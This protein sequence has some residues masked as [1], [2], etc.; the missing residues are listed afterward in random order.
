MLYEIDEIFNKADKI[1][2]E[3][4]DQEIIKLFEFSYNLQKKLYKNKKNSEMLFLIPLRD[5]LVKILIDN[6]DLSWR[7]RIK[8]F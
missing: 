1:L 5:Q 6:N 7:R 8:W 3:M 4:N 2:D